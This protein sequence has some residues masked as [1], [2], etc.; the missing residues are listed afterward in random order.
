MEEPS[1]KKTFDPGKS[2]DLTRTGRDMDDM[3]PEVVE[4]RKVIEA[5]R[6]DPSYDH[7]FALQQAAACEDPMQGIELLLNCISE[8]QR[9][10]IANLVHTE[11][12]IKLPAKE[13]FMP[14]VLFDSG[15]QTSSY[16]SAELV[17]QHMD[18]LGELLEPA[19][20]MIQLG[21]HTTKKKV[22]RSVTLPVS[23]VTE[24]LEEVVGSVRCYVWSMPGMDMIVGMPDICAHFS[25]V[26]MEMLQKGVAAASEDPTPV[27]TLSELYRWGSTYEEAPEDEETELPSSFGGPLYYLLTSR[28][29]AIQELK[30][31][32]D[33]HVDPQFRAATPIADFLQ[34]FIPEKWEGMKGFE[35]LELSFLPTLPTA[36]K[37]RARPVNPKLM[38]AAKKEFSRLLTYFYRPSTSPIASCLVIAPKATSPFIRFCG[39]YVDINKHIVRYQAYIP[40]VQHALEKAAGFK[41]YLDIDLANSFHQIKLGDNTSRVLAV[42]TP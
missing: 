40:N 12:L 9:N 18:V 5:K 1:P 23:F 7:V 24:S 37:P 36:K 32:L 2:P 33:D 10:T 39:D 8:G 17:E 38:E 3:P 20:L 22:D 19:S 42:Q 30:K 16:I 14:R 4:T 15:A 27:E 13:V 31:I 21:D 34:C 6:K 41:V 29:E 28:E 35:P 26:F 11:G 25:S